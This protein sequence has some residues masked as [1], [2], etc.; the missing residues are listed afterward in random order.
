[1]LSD[2]HTNNILQVTKHLGKQNGVPVFGALH[3]CINE[4]NEICS[5]ILTPMKAHDQYMPALVAIS[6][7][8]HTYGHPPVELIFTDNVHADKMELENVFSSL[9]LNVEQIPDHSSLEHLKYPSDWGITILS[10]PFQIEN[11][12]RSIMEDIPDGGELFVGMDI[13]WPAD[14]FSSIQ[15]QVAVISIACNQ[16][17]YLL[18]VSDCIQFFE[19]SLLMVV[20]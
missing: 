15:G 5:M 13:E 18:Q 17:I 16:E 1:M 2:K 7:S 20:D 8:L 4:Y 6:Q 3:S 10:S 9:Q 11:R 12:L 14:H 19:I